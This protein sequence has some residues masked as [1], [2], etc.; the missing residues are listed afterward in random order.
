MYK[1]DNDNSSGDLLSFPVSVFRVLDELIYI[2]MLFNV[3]KKV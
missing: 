1:F 3:K 2:Q